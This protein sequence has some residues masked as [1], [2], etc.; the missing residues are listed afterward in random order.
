M[1]DVIEASR[2]A[3]KAVDAMIADYAQKGPTKPD[4]VI[5]PRWEKPPII[6]AKTFTNTLDKVAFK[7]G[8]K[9]SKILN[10]WKDLVDVFR[11]YKNEVMLCSE[12]I[13][14]RNAFKQYNHKDD[15]V[16][17]NELVNMRRSGLNFIPVDPSIATT[18][19]KRNEFIE[20]EGE[21]LKKIKSNI[22]NFT[23]IYQHKSVGHGG[24]PQEIGMVLH[25]EVVRTCKAMGDYSDRVTEEFV[26]YDPTANSSALIRARYLENLSENLFQNHE[27]GLVIQLMKKL[28]IRNKD[29]EGQEYQ[30]LYVMTLCE[31]IPLSKWPSSLKEELKKSYKHEIN[32]PYLLRPL[33][34]S[35]AKNH[36]QSL[37]RLNDRLGS[38]GFS[39]EQKST[40]ETSL[41]S[42][43][44][45][46]LRP[47]AKRAIK[48]YIE[49]N[50]ITCSHST[51][52]SR[53][54]CNNSLKSS[55]YHIGHIFSQYWCEAYVIFQESMNHP[56]NL[57]LSCPECNVKLQQGCPDKYMLTSINK[58]RLTIGDLLRQGKLQQ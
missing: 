37:I 26:T 34:P 14:F 40:L 47:R 4:F 15:E 38:D 21:D 5:H 17:I 31:V 33:D 35:D 54:K 39:L 23:S 41:V 20:F 16:D 52:S 18:I 30:V 51:N 55:N 44:S 58:E 32:F 36:I 13:A 43:W 57:Y 6:Q 8:A 29:F 28:K 49:H 50:D 24:M 10:V 22:N 48:E 3:R 53:I 19:K 1:V 46:P 9:D 12:P 7:N 25:N 11:A 27:M 56:D 42:E 2:N 45:Y